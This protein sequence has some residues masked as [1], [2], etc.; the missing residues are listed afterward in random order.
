MYFNY[1]NISVLE[2]YDQ[3]GAFHFEF[4][5]ENFIYTCYSAIWVKDTRIRRE[6]I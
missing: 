6:T 1:T 4:C 5:N 3:I 2:E